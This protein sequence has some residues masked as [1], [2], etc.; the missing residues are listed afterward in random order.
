MDFVEEKQPKAFGLD[1]GMGAIK[2]YRPGFA[3]ELPSQ[4]SISTNGPQAQVSGLRRQRPPLQ[5]RNDYGSFYVGKGAHSWGHPVEYL[6]YDR[7]SDSPEM[8]AL[9]YAAFTR[10]IRQHG[11]LDAPLHLTIGL[12]SVPILSETRTLGN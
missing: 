7:F 9:L 6:G 12:P 5:I 3:L 1:P 8:S 10:F 11:E 4:V 2:L